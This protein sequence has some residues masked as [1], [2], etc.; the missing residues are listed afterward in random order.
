VAVSISVVERARAGAT[1]E[2]ARLVMAV[3]NR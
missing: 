2:P 1:G 3:S